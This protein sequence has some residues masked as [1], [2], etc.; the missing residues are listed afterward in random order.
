MAVLVIA[1]H[2][3]ASVRGATFNTVTA[4]LQCGGEVHVLIAGANAGAAA[5]AAA[6]IAGVAKVLHA[7]GAQFAHG[8]A[9]N[10]AAQV[11]AIVGNDASRYGHILFP[12][13][14]HGKNV[15]HQPCKQLHG[16]VLEGEGRAV[17]QL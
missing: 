16:N 5:A 10:V 3:H 6:Q 9:E 14:A 17:E 11:L 13:T 2:D 12:A 15:V 1:E 4:A 8:L 7:D